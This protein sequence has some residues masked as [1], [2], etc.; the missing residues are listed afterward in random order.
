MLGKNVSTP[1][2]VHM[3]EGGVEKDGPSAAVAFF[4]ALLSKETGCV[5][6]D[7]AFTGEL[8]LSGCV[9]PVGGVH[10]K[11]VAAERAGIKRVFVPRYNYD[12]LRRDAFENIEIIP[13]EHVIE[14]WKVAGEIYDRKQTNIICN[15]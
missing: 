5:W 12:R 1:L 10:E 4:A 2:Y 7:T 15:Q 6:S 9:R 8:D 11:V 3:G 13:I 14:L